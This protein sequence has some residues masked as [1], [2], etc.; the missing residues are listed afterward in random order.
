MIRLILSLL[1]TSLAMII[2]LP[3][4]WRW[5]HIAKT[6]PEVSWA[7]SRKVIRFFFRGLIRLA[8]TR[9]EVRGAENI[10]D[11]AALFV[12]NHRSYFDIIIMQTLS[13]TPMG[14]VAKK[15]F[16]SY[17]LLPLYM[18]D[19]GSIFLDRENVRESLKTIND[20]TER[21]GK[22]L[23][24]G[25]YPEGTRNHGEEL[26]PFR[27]GGYRMAEKSDSPI[28][29]MAATNFGKIF[30]ENRFHFIRSRHAIIEFDKPVYPGRMTKDERKAFYD[31]IPDRI[32]GM[33]DIHKKDLLA[34][35]NAKKKVRKTP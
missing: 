29:L 10:P 30:E 20:G 8:G 24:L 22:G 35:Q 11:T 28:V 4:H 18:E 12:G 13:K 25:L 7:K 33:L 21:M 17:P 9:L 3:A 15:E 5:K 34:E 31:S 14:F 27:A 26:L 19:M 32:Q 2:T 1:W 16:R 6:R 23:S